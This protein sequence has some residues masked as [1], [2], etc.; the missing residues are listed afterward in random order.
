MAEPL[1]ER[2]VFNGP[3]KI[4]TVRTGDQIYPSVLANAGGTW[5]FVGS[6]GSDESAFAIGDSLIAVFKKAFTPMTT[7]G[8][9]NFLFVFGLT[10]QDLFID[11]EK[12]TV[13]FM[14]RICEELINQ[15][16]TK[17]GVTPHTLRNLR[18]WADSL[19]EEN[20]QQLKKT[21]EATITKLQNL[22]EEPQTPPIKPAAIK[23]KSASTLEALERLS[24][25]IDQPKNP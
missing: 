16:R 8:F 3:G 11:S 15:V 19:T 25:H 2:S 12:Q 5:I 22:P 14:G 21:L 23:L 1:V 17:K 18:E 6:I 7:N 13:D 20:S 10:L 4:I 9:R 24:G